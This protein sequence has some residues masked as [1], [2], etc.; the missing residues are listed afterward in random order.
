MESIDKRCT[1][2]KRKYESC[3]NAWYAGAYLRGDRN[4]PCTELFKEYRLC[5]DSALRDRQVHSLIEEHHRV[6]GQPSQGPN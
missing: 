2:L 5:I 3:F 1:E 4:D 6:H